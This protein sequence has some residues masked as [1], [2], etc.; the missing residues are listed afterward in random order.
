M[1]PKTPTLTDEQIESLLYKHR[2]DMVCYDHPE[3][4]CCACGEHKVGGYREHLGDLIARMVA[5]A[6]QRGRAEVSA[7]VEAAL[8]STESFASQKAHVEAVYSSASERGL[9]LGSLRVEERLATRVRAALPDPAAAVARIKAESW[10]ECAREA[11]D[12]GWMHD[13]ALWDVL[14]RNPYRGGDHA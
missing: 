9:M 14:R 5:D 4:Y 3:D 1:P 10:D 13:H 6:E 11:T 12:L 8:P 2:G 7:A